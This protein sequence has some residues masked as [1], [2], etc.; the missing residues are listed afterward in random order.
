MSLL[1]LKLDGWFDK[2][3]P[4]RPLTD[5]ELESLRGGNTISVFWNNETL[6]IYIK[7]KALAR[8]KIQSSDVVIRKVT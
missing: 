8:N 7:P 6:S 5:K 4:L 1:Q 2:G 3:V